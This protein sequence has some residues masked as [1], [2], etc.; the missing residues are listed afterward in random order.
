MLSFRPFGS[1]TRMPTFVGIIH[2]LVKSGRFW[3]VFCHRTINCALNIPALCLSFP[4]RTGL[5]PYFI[6]SPWLRAVVLIHLIQGFSQLFLD[7]PILSAVGLFTV[8]ST[9]WGQV[10][11]A[12]TG[13]LRGVFFRLKLATGPKC[14][15][16]SAA[17]FLRQGLIFGR[18]RWRSL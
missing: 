7:F 12:V 17:H 9:H 14:A 13:A 8:A 3:A 18:P 6:S 4:T 2:V 10:R 1:C 11:R 15:R 16:Y 5:P